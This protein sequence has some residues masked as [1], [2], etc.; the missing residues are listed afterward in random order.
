[1]AAGA[2]DSAQTEVTILDENTCAVDY[3]EPFSVYDGLCCHLNVDCQSICCMDG[4]CSPKEPCPHYDG[5]IDEYE[6]DNFN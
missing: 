4:V 1:M 3:I 6:R 5:S 2:G